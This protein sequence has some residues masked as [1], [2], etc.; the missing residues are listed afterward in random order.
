MHMVKE[1]IMF[2]ARQ[3]TEELMNPRLRRLGPHGRAKHFIS[4]A[5]VITIVTIVLVINALFLH[6]KMLITGPIYLSFFVLIAL[7]YLGV[8]LIFKR[9]ILVRSIRMYKGTKLAKFAGAIG[10]GYMLL[11]LA[12]IILTIVFGLKMH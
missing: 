11:N 5:L 4:M 1:L 2:I 6:K 12:V 8:S 7:I 3:T 10:L 9:N